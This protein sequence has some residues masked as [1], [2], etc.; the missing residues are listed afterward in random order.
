MNR[1]DRE[2]EELPKSLS[3][4][5][6]SSSPLELP[7][8]GSYKEK[9][10]KLLREGNTRTDKRG[11]KVDIPPGYSYQEGPDGVGVAIPPCATT[12]IDKVGRLHPVPKGYVMKI[13]KNGKG[14]VV[15]QGEPTRQT[16]EGQLELIKRL[17]K[18]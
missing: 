3:I 12:E 10:L 8:L 7:P 13:G 1:F 6:D 9:F 18:P 5:E 11:N 4:E 15:P 14:L 2:V 16:K 17:K